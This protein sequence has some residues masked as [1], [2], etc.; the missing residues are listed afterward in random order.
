MPLKLIG[1]VS[2]TNYSALPLRRCS[3][4][5]LPGVAF[6]KGAFGVFS[7]VPVRISC[8]VDAFEAYPRSW[9]RTCNHRRGKKQQQQQQHVGEFSLITWRTDEWLIY[10]PPTG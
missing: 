6:G 5:V 4:D 9:F 10:L 3:C 8:G 7:T 2:P 1:C